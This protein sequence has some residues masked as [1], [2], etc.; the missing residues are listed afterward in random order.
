[1][2]MAL[3]L[4][5]GVLLGFGTRVEA[6]LIAQYTGGIV[7]YGDSAT[8]TPKYKVFDDA[9]GFGSEQ[10]ATAVG[11]TTIEWIRV[12]ASPTRDEWIIVTRDAADIIVSQVCTGVD[13]GISCGATTTVTA[14]AGTHGLRNFDV[15][16]E[17]SSGDALIVYGT[18]TADELRSIQWNGTSW[19]GD[20][21]IT[22]T[23]TSGTV[24]WVEL[25]SRPG[26]DQIAI[27]YSDSNDDISAYRWSGTAVGNEATAVITASGSTADVRKFD[28]SFEGTSGDMI[29]AAP[30]AGAGTTALGHMTS[31]GTWTIVAN[32]E[33]DNI[34][35]YIDLQEV[36]AD[37]DVAMIAHGTTTT[38]NPSEGYELNGATPNTTT[39]GMVDST[40]AVDTTTLNWIANY[41][42][43]SVA[44][45]SS[46][47]YAVG[48]FSDVTGADDI[49]W[50]TMNSSG[51]WTVQ[52]DNTRTRGTVRFTDIFDYPNTNKVLLLSSDA[53][54][55]LWADTW[56][57]AATGTS[58]WT[59]VTSGGAIETILSAS[60]TDVYDF[61]FRL[62]PL[63]IQISG[64]LYQSD[65]STTGAAGETI[66][67][68]IATSS[69]PAVLSTTTASGGVWSFDNI[70]TAV[71]AATSG[72]PY[73]IWLDGTSTKATTLL[74]GNASSSAL[75]VHLYQDHL[76]VN[77]STTA[78]AVNLAN[79]AIYDSSD[80]ADVLYTITGSAAT[81]TANFFIRQGAFTPTATFAV[82]G[83]YTNNGTFT[84]GSGTLQFVATTS[85]QRLSGTYTGTSAF[86]DVVF[87]G[88]VGNDKF[89]SGNASTSDLTISTGTTLYA[90]SS[91]TVFGDYTN[92]GTL[93]SS[94]TSNIYLTG[95]NI[96]ATG[97]MTGTSSFNSLVLSG[98]GT[99]LFGARASTT[100]FSVLSTSG[101][102]IM[103]AVITVSGNYTNNSTT[104]GAAVTWTA[105]SGV[106]GDNDSW[107]GITYGNGLFVAVSN[108]GDRVMTSPDGINW[109]AR[110]AVDGDDAWNGVTYGN[111]LFVAV[112]QSGDRVM[113]SPD[114]TNWTART[115][116]G[117]D[118]DWAD[119]VFGNGLF[120][121]VGAVLNDRVMTSPDGI[122]WTARTAAGDD[123]VW[124]G[125]TYG[126]GLFVAVGD[127]GSGDA[128]MTSPDGTTWTAR[129]AFSDFTDWQSVT[130]GNG[131]FV[132]VANAGSLRV[133][134]SPDGTTWTSRSA[135]GDDDVWNSVTYGNGLFVATGD[136]SGA[137]DPIMASSD[138]INWTARSAAGNDD[139]WFSLTHSGGQFVV[140]GES[141]SRAM[142]SEDAV[143]RF[144]GASSQ[145]ISGNL[146][147]ASQLRAVEFSGAGTKTFSSNASSTN[148]TIATSSAVNLPS[149]LSVMG[150]YTNSGS[151]EAGT[152]VVYLSGSA[153]QTI[154]G[155]LATTNAFNNLIV[156]NTS[157]V[158]STS[159]T[160]TL[161]VDDTLTVEG[162]AFVTLQAGA[163][164]TVATLNLN[165]SSS[166]PVA[167]G[168]TATG[169]QAKL[170]VTGTPT[171]TYA[172]IYDNNACGSTGGVIDVSS[173]NNTD[174]GNTTCWSFVDVTPVI[175]LGSN[176]HFYLGQ[177][178]T[179]FP[180]ITITEDTTA[181]ITAANDIRLTIATTTTNFRFDVGVA[182]LTFDGT[183]SG[184]VS[185][186]VSYEDGGATLLIPVSSDFAGSETLT[187][188]GIEVGNFAAISAT[189]SRLMLHTDGNA[190]G[191]PDASSSETI[192]ITGTLTVAEHDA[193]QA[194]NEFSWQNRS[195]ATFYAF[196]LTP[197]GENATITDMVIDVSGISKITTSDMS[198][199]KL[200]RD[201]DS[202]GVLDGTD[203]LLD[204]SGVLTING[205]FGAVTFSSD[206]LATTSVNYIMTADTTSIPPNGALIFDLVPT[207]G[208]T[209]LG[210]TSLYDSYG[211]G[212]VTS[213]QHI[214][215]ASGGGGMNV[216]IGDDA[217]TGGG[218]MS[219]GESGG[220]SGVGESEGENI[221]A[222]ADY[223]RPTDI[224]TP[225]EW[226][227]PT[228]GYASDGSY[229]TAATNGFRQTY[230]NFGFGIPPTNTIE[231]IAVKLDA[232]GSTAAGTIDV[233]LSWDGGS[234]YTT[235]KAT[236]TLS[237]SDVVYSVGGPSDGW[238]R[239][240]SVGELS[241]G[242]FRLRV[243]GNVS[244]NTLRIDALEVR[245]HHQAT[246]GNSGGGGG[247]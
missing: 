223:Y 5:G 59:D 101:E 116:A 158:A 3:C 197:A 63:P 75:T 120:V 43:A 135:A 125:I 193:G 2:V 33:P 218:I 130:Y 87:V 15:A 155:A 237:G 145:T 88:T 100:N 230:I 162:G 176:Q 90:T 16:Y 91:V 17:R 154:T 129:T 183:A 214:R 233:A 180:T 234:S 122:N 69:S 246:G 77:G 84:H 143:L 85:A 181:A 179:T 137:G 66:K 138:G 58:A 192:A 172:R 131:L 55:D 11:S 10:S 81:T 167:F 68:A 89:V 199:F 40:V 126:N 213:V 123:D 182:T 189:T 52:A 78:S 247:I 165:G 188:G 175:S 118:D 61:A 72:T 166:A 18:A 152:G 32:T 108:F 216:R 13:G 46:T 26:S 204:G 7:V 97:T 20:A 121:A 177:G 105:Q 194:D 240:W 144:T 209:G 203:I 103:P 4:I 141:G 86:N 6:A 196:K 25:T 124:H 53:N 51:V 173:G 92:N 136:A 153:P 149:A 243:T 109:T 82:L 19:T 70:G 211:L 49:N 191:A 114:G 156:K 110:S 170:V 226:T 184:K 195:D 115:A 107:R 231:G 64:V 239:T 24:E 232:S 38:N 147:G 8:G 112:S 163:T 34:T 186:P 79:F 244:S 242:N 23:R 56:A 205:Q 71:S 83:N 36:G 168:S 9:T 139:T 12:A 151:V 117:D 74:S 65:R 200:Y 221:V 80:D 142:A 42:H 102:V 48:I 146:V 178:T 127:D 198:D 148:F 222:D 45:L 106:A 229:A 171:V 44:Y 62:A 104:T 128:V 113:T 132:A 245:I 208:L 50:W 164:T 157:R 202:D 94:S 220:G 236:P 27:G 215:N 47:Y 31:A 217:P 39:T 21:A 134:T 185:N 169:T 96:T 30:L 159:F 67:L 73:T 57:G 187:I 28:V 206:F 93:Q 35:S 174:G 29:V 235:A 212:S 133:M 160:G 111:G 76:V 225:S 1:M 60:S 207:T 54:S 210:V 99:K 140:V 41:M 14:T 224:G 37:D 98:A 150:N 238:G 201:T 190:I 219:G 119:V 227:N 22:T 241:N 228:N 161:T 95:S